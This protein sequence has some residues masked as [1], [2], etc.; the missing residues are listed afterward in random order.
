MSGRSEDADGENRNGSKPSPSA[1]RDI[2]AR[3]K[4]LLEVDVRLALI[5][6]P[7]TLPIDHDIL[8]VTD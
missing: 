7:A 6:T 2:E 8:C 4:T 3:E 5:I 1:V